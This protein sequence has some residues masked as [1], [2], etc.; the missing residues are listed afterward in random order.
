MNAN[1]KKPVLSILVASALFSFSGQGFATTIEQGDFSPEISDG[2]AGAISVT[3]TDTLV[4]TDLSA[5]FPKGVTGVI[6][7]QT[8]GTIDPSKLSNPEALLKERLTLGYM[9]HGISAPDPITGGKI[10]VQTYNTTGFSALPTA[11]DADVALYDLTNVGDNQYI[12]LRIADVANTGKLDVEFGTTGTT[13][14]HRTGTN[15][16]DIAAKQTT[17]F[18]VEGEINWKTNNRVTFSA[19]S[20]NINNPKGTYTVTNIPVYGGKFAV[21]T[22]HPITGDKIDHEFDVTDLATLS[23]YNSQLIDWLENGLLAPSSYEALFHKGVKLT[24]ENITYDYSVDTTMPDDDIFKP[25]GNNTVIHATGADAKATIDALLETDYTYGYGNSST[26]VSKVAVKVDDGGKLDIATGATLGV[27]NGTAL[28]LSGTGSSATNNGTI[29]GNFLV[30]P[31]SSGNLVIDTSKTNDRGVTVVRVSDASS[32]DNQGTINLSSSGK[33]TNEN[34]GI[35]INNTAPATACSVGGG[36]YAV[37]N[38]GKINIGM[39]SS[40]SDNATTGVYLASANASFVNTG[41]IN[42]GFGYAGVDDVTLNQKKLTSGIRV[43]DGAVATNEGRITIG[44]LTQNAAGMYAQ[45]DPKNTLGDS[46]SMTNNGGIIINGK[47]GGTPNLNHGMLIIDAGKDGNITNNGGI[48]VNGVNGVGISV[49]STGASDARAITTSTSQIIVAGDVDT[50]SGTRNYGVWVEGRGSGLASASV[51]GRIRLTGEG[52]IGVHARGNATVTVTEDATPQFFTGERQIGFFAYGDNAKIDVQNSSNSFTVSTNKSTVFRLENGADLNTDGLKI[53]TRATESVGING[54]GKN[55]HISLTNGSQLNLEGLGSTGVI[56][57]GG[58]TGNFDASSQFDFTGDGTIGARVDG[59][60]HN[61][62]NGTTDFGVASTKL[63]SSAQLLNNSGAK[64]V[65]GYLVQN[66]GNLD[67]TADSL[68]NFTSGTDNTGVHIN[69]NGKLNN[70]GTIH[71]AHGTG[72]KAEGAGAQTAKAGIIAVDDGTAGVQLLNNASLTLTGSDSQIATAGSAHGVLMDTDARALKV[73]DATLTVNGT[74]NGIENKAET[75]NIS[76][77]NAKINV[78]GGAGIRTGVTIDPAST[79]QIN[80]SGAG[81]G[82]AFMDAAHAMVTGDLML[83][84]GYNINATGA[85]GVGIHANTSGQVQ[86]ATNVNITHAN[87]G[88]A[89][90]SGTASRTINQGSLISNSQIAPVVDLAGAGTEF[91]NLGTILAADASKVAVQGSNGDDTLSFVNG[92]VRGDINSG[93]GTKDTLYMQG[94]QLDGSITMGATDSEAYIMKT[95]LSKAAHITSVAGGDST[96]TFN[97]IQARGGSFVADDLAKGTNLGSGWHTIKLI[98]STQFTLTDNLQLSGSEVYIEP[99]ST[100]FAGGNKTQ[101]MIAGGAPGSVTVTNKGMIDL[102][103]DGNTTGDTLTVKGN[104]DATPGAFA[105]GGQLALN[106]LMN[107]G[108]AKAMQHT[109]RLLVENN[110]SGVTMIDVRQE[111]VNADTGAVTDLDRNEFISSN[112]GI[113]VVQVAGNSTADAF[114]LKGGYVSAGAFRYDLYAF[115]PGASDPAQRYVSGA[116]SNYWDYRLANAFVCPTGTDCTNLRL[117]LTPEAPAYISLTNG[118][119]QYGSQNIDDLHKRLGELREQDFNGDNKE[120]F[121]RYVRSD[122]TYHTNVDPKN[123]GFDFDLD[124]NILQVGGNFLKL[125]N[126]DSLFRVGL[127][128]S[129]GD[130]DLK[131]D[132]VDG[133]SKTKLKSD[134]AALFLTWHNK[135]NA[136]IDGVLTYDWH[137]AKVNTNDY[138]QV[139]K[140]KGNSWSAS[141]EGGYPYVFDNGYTLEPQ[142]QLTYQELSLKDTVDEKGARVQFGKHSQTIGRLG[143]RADKTWITEDGKL[144]TPYLRLNYYQSWGGASSVNISDSRS[145]SGGASFKGGDFGQALQVGLGLTATFKNNFSLYGEVD[146]QKEIN[147]GMRGVRF[148]IGGKWLF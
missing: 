48:G 93:A 37:C 100:L 4:S 111:G 125:R 43:Y 89:L 105:Y 144:F 77:N 117:G 39:V 36:D 49:I 2:Q 45:G 53:T 141:I 34:I 96:L 14:D 42:I 108:G 11:K 17:L 123:Y 47:A 12:D 32:F 135:K 57:E 54:T 63:T 1:F 9:V 92:T 50:L 22:T 115:A 28:A 128:W 124:T 88:S 119:A 65:T 97:N 38:S 73:N 51:D 66:L 134:S 116:G 72:L 61:L 59:N 127:A 69:Y 31:D 114:V 136:Y 68:I 98:G 29:N 102:S 147:A 7:T 138:G 129:H 33:Y 133:Y 30:K 113:S 10:S 109:D 82:F 40:S 46:I 79:A 5:G 6:T 132:A 86:L 120:V 60:K 18:E 94:T 23:A 13:D 15:H 20:A 52:A 70:D 131:S 44:A 130:S 103:N 85:G 26:D 148:N 84:S 112:E 118:L 90:I 64:N 91:L 27:F 3:G 67:L 142:A 122:Y 104:Y 95:D 121:A 101:W 58:A 106:T 25:I 19:A 80:V 24:S 55:T 83:G 71:V 140:I 74:G 87:G 146:Y 62:A 56:I 143:V 21:T 139:D 137:E 107:E 99:N 110:V 78:T 8:T 35:Y 145:Q 76:L 16:L 126:E 81:T 75:G 41:D